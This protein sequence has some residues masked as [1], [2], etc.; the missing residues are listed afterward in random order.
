MFASVVSAHA[1]QTTGSIV[2]T[3]KDETGAVV[4]AATVKATNVETGFSRAAPTNSYGQ[5]RIDYLPVGGYTVELEAT[6]F[7][8]FVQRNIA[9][10]VDQTQTV[11]IT[12]SVGAAT[13]TVTV[14]TAPPLVNTSDA[15]LGRTVEGA[16][17]LGLPLVN[18]NAYS[19]I[20]LTP[21]VMA[22]NNSPTSNPTGS[23]NFTVGL[24]SAD[25]QINGSIDGGNPEV[26]FYLDGGNN[27]TGMRNYG[28]PAPNPDALEEFRVETSAF[29]AQYGQFS[30][31]V[32]TVITK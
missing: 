27:I 10:N 19:E 11:D 25:V 20:S 3:V 23:P 8:R 31:A 17:I 29:G 18:R 28:N 5:Y 21:G 7:R 2:G 32:I 15:V 13:E 16:E 9:L 26:A 14:T 12:L 1:Q 30:A 4:S 24:P 22:N 6:G